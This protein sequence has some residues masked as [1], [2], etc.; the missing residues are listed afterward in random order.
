[1][2]GV[3]DLSHCLFLSLMLIGGWLDATW[4]RVVAHHPGM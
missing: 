2:P 1:M 3:L 4:A